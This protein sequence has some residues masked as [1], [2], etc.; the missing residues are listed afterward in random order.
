MELPVI[1]T[2]QMYGE[3]R[4]CFT[5]PDEAERTLAQFKGLMEVAAEF[6]AMINIGRVCGPYF[7]TISRSEAE[8][9]F[10]VS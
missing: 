1:S 2:G 9:I 5:D 3:S 6:G 4:L 8:D 7:P 10:F